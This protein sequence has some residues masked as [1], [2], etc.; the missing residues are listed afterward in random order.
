M[1]SNQI[2]LFSRRREKHP[3]SADLA[4]SQWRDAMRDIGDMLS[5][6]YQDLRG[7]LADGFSDLKR[8]VRWALRKIS[9]KRNG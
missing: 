6:I 7:D 1:P 4:A 8:S 5:G 2:Q 3:Q 9:S